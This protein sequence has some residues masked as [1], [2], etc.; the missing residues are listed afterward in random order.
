MVDMH[1]GENLV[2]GSPPSTSS[3]MAP[4]AEET[5]SSCEDTSQEDENDVAL[6]KCEKSG[7]AELI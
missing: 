2:P 3:E 7:E 5:L 1:P 6:G 4:G